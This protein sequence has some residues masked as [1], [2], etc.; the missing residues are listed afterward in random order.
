MLLGLSD[1]QMWPE[2][3]RSG[4]RGPRGVGQTLGSPHTAPILV[5][6]L[7]AGPLGG[8]PCTQA[9]PSVGEQQT[10]A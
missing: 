6:P 2:D 1:G 7:T 3:G 5:L 8:E 9:D 10:S 4:W